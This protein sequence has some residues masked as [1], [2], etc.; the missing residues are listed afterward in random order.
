MSAVKISV[1]SKKSFKTTNAETKRQLDENTKSESARS[2]RPFYV[3]QGLSFWFLSLK[4]GLRCSRGRR[5]VPTMC[6]G[7]GCA[8]LG[9]LLQKINFRMSFQV[10]SQ[11]DINFGVSF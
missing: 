6:T 5:G 4:R 10:R 8:F 3:H 7:T 9:C 2:D 1:F 11:I